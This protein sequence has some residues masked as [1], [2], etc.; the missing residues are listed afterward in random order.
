MPIVETVD[1]V[2]SGRV[3]VS[4]AIRALMS[5]EMKSELGGSA[6]DNRYD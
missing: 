4:G 5:R 6:F 3:E 1:G 2:V